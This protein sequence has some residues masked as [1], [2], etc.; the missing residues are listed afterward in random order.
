MDEAEDDEV[1]R[2]IRKKYG[3]KDPPPD[4]VNGDEV[5]ISHRYRDNLWNLI[6]IPLIMLPTALYL[7]TKYVIA[8]GFSLVIIMIGASDARSYDLSVRLRRAT[9]LLHEIRNHINSK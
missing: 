9:I 7:D 6:F 4:N 5:R 1:Y 2:R 3:F 8:V